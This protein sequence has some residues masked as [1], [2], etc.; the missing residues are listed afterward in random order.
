MKLIRIMVQ[1]QNWEIS[2]EF[3]IFWHTYCQY[4][5]LGFSSKIEVPQLGS[6]RLGTFTAQ[7]R[8]SRKF[9]ARTHLYHLGMFGYRIILLKVTSLTLHCTGAKCNVIGVKFMKLGRK[10]FSSSQE[11]LGGG[12]YWAFL[13][14]TPTASLL[15]LCTRGVKK[16]WT[17]ILIFYCCIVFLKNSGAYSIIS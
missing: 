10:C 11:I 7:A 2:L 3:A 8:S 13:V 16:F 14:L 12:G 4:C 17:C 5:Q 15:W 9:P 1:K 6:T